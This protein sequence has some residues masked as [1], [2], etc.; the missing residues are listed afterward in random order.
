MLHQGCEPGRT[1]FVDSAEGGLGDDEEFSF[2]TVEF[3][4]ILLHP[5]LYGRQAGLNVGVG[6][7]MGGW[8]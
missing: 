3:E 4:D 8:V 5:D 7:V 2:V 6:W 1:G